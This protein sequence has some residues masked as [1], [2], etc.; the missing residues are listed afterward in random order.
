MRI[1]GLH[2][3]TGLLLDPLTVWLADTQGGIIISVGW[4]GIPYGSRQAGPA[5]PLDALGPLVATDAIAIAGGEFQRVENT[6]FWNALKNVSVTASAL[7]PTAAGKLAVLNFVDTRIDLTAA[8][9]DGFEILVIGAKRGLIRTD[10][11]DGADHVTL[12]SHSNEGT[13]SNL[14][15]I[16][17]FGGDD[18]IDIT[19]VAA[20]RLDD[21]HL[22]ANADADEPLWNAGYDGRF[23][24]YFVDAGAGDDVVTVRGA[25]QAVIIG[26]QGNDVLRGG[27]GNDWIDGGEGSDVLFGGLGADTFV[28]NHGEI[29]NDV[30]GDFTRAPGGGGDQLLFIGFGAEASLLTVDAEAGL[31]GVSDGP[32]SE[33]AFLIV[34]GLGGAPLGEGD[35]LFV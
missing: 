33:L 4:D 2:P 15:V 5:I 28:F 17:T 13:W 19:T 29:D 30:V 11:G 35:Y 34:L 27:A 22:G 12:V 24:H 20:A 23:S 6:T 26:G 25:G 7:D 32:G 8:G 9:G 3:L 18:R 10:V 1:P 16:E 14:T 21:L 31:Y